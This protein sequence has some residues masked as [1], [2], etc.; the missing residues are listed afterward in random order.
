MIA[1]AHAAGLPRKLMRPSPPT[2]VPSGS[3]QAG[4]PLRGMA[5]GLTGLLGAFWLAL[6]LTALLQG[7]G[8]PIPWLPGSAPVHFDLLAAAAVA[9][10]CLAGRDRLPR[11]SRGLAVLLILGATLSLILLASPG[12]HLSIAAE[13]GLHAGHMGPVAA[14]GFLMAGI[15][16]FVPLAARATPGNVTLGWSV[17]MTM[18]ALALTL[19][20][21]SLDVLPQ[22][23]AWTRHTAA[24]PDAA[25]V[26]L[27]LGAACAARTFHAS[28]DIAPL[29]LLAVQSITLIGGIVASFTIWQANA[30]AAPDSIIPAI[31]FAACL[32]A[33]Y[34]I[35]GLLAL[36][37]RITIQ[38]R[39]MNEATAALQVSNDLFQAAARS[40]RLGIWEWNLTTGEVFIIA[41]YLQPQNGSQLASRT[42]IEAFNALIHPEDRARVAKEFGETLRTGRTF[43]AEFR[44]QRGDGRHLWVL[45]RADLGRDGQSRSR[46]LIGSIE[47]IDQIKRQMTELEWQRQMLEEQSVKLAETAQALTAAKNAAESAH[48]AKSSF[49]AMMSHEIR[50]PMNGVLGMLSLLQRGTEDQQMRRYADVAQQSARDLLGL[51]DDILDVSK[52][53]AG[54][55]EIEAIDFDL[56]PTLESVISLLTPRAIENGNCLQLDCAE[57]VPENVIGDPLRLRQILANLIGNA[58]KFTENGSIDVT[59]TATRL[60]NGEFM[61]HCAVRDTGIGIPAEIQDRLFEPFTQADASMTRRYGGTGLGL[62]ICRHLVHLMGGEIGVISAP[63]EGSTFWFTL[64]CR[65]DVELLARLAQEDDGFAVSPPAN[66]LPKGNQTA[67]SEVMHRQDSGNTRR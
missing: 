11:L 37:V 22:T 41:N 9:T 10:G 25:I 34:L 57:D 1:C 4:W 8:T 63:G 54:K 36:A 27:L 16:L 42:T 64:R 45:A 29:P 67:P 52:L 58:I 55:L 44:L 62:T 61:L 17:A 59:L 53:E 15:R 56:R 32:L 18:V 40:S 23:A 13:P 24:L 14:F 30:A 5:Y 3:G 7:G 50:T 49:L 48:R 20:I 60:Q 28:P 31:S 2:I 33:T 47:D 66:D 38:Q 12:P 43:E 65:E 19:A 51:I 26:L 21:G 6:S 46:R 35:A 39:I